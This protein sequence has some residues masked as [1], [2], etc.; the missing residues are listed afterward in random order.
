MSANAVFFLVLDVA[1]FAG[2]EHFMNET[3]GLAENIRSCPKAEGVRDITL[4]GDPERNTKATRLQTGIAI[5]DGTWNQLVTMAKKLH[6][7]VPF[8]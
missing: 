1:Q 2:V 4:P 7:D 5:D 3:T 8:I 6:V